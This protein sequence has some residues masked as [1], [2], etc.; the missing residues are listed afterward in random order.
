MSIQHCWCAYFWDL[1][2]SIQLCWCAY[3]WDLF[4]ARV[5]NRCFL[6]Y[7]TWLGCLFFVLIYIH[8]I[9]LGWSGA[10]FW[11]LFISIPFNFVGKGVLIWSWHILAR[12]ASRL[13]TKSVLS[14]SGLPEKVSHCLFQLPRGSFKLQSYRGT[15]MSEKKYLSLKI[16]QLDFSQTLA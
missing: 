2:M 15:F 9:Q 1:F 10:Y 13:N 16:R 8:P 7:S 4:F 3:F 6:A 14:W 5:F 11:Y 12:A